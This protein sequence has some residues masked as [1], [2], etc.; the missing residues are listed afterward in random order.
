MAESNVKLIV[1]ATQAVGPLKQ[2]TA[3][4]TQKLEQ[5]V[6]KTNGQLRATT[7]EL[8]RT[9]KAAATATGDIQRFGV[10]FRTTLA[11][12]VAATGAVTF[13]SRS[14]NVLGQREANAAALLNG[15]RKLGEG[16]EALRRLQQSADALGKATLFDQGILI[17]DL[18]C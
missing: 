5:S 16:E 3:A 10:A 15:L 1:D 18:R 4:A 13:L 2:T 7:G 8:G 17:V 14:L 9:G 11:P 12:I 6:K